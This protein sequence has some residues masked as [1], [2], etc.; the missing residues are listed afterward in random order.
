VTALPSESYRLDYWL[1]DGIPAGSDNPI[2]IL[3]TDDHTLQPVFAENHIL[4]ITVS[5]GGTTNP[6]PGTYTY[7]TPTDVSVTAI[8]FTNYRFD[9]WELDTVNIGSAN[10]VTVHV[11]SSHTLHAV[12]VLITYTLEIQ[13]T[14]GGTTSPTPGTYTH[15]AGSTVQVTASPNTNYVFDHWE[16]DT[17]NVGSAN[18]Y[19]VLMDQNHTLKA[20]FESAPSAPSVSISPLSASIHVGQS[21]IFTS[22]VSGGTPPYSYQWYLD[23]APVSGATSASWTYTP[24]S[25]SVHSVK[26]KVIDSNSNTAWSG[27]AY[28]TVTDGVPVGG[29]SVSLAKPLPIAQL[30]SYSMIVALFGVAISLTRRKRK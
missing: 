19:S 23:D 21:V 8:P 13:T 30:A 12:F 5:A 15:N 27:V 1:L 2:S 17:V 4:E 7:L 29:Y 22:I 18:P 10:P 11:G 24:T 28:I 6:Q 14:A 25:A 9:H 3:M 20:V 26:L 16:L